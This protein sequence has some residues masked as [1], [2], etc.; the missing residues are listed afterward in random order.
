MDRNARVRAHT[1]THMYINPQ[2]ARGFP[3]PPGTGTPVAPQFRG[4]LCPSPRRS[5]P[6]QDLRLQPANTIASAVS[7]SAGQG[8]LAAP[9]DDARVPLSRD[10]DALEFRKPNMSREQ[11]NTDTHF[12]IFIHYFISLPPSLSIY[13]SL[14]LSITP[15]LSR[16]LPISLGH[17][18]TPS[19]SVS[20][21][22]INAYKHVLLEKQ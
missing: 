14:S 13:Q 15:Y 3:V 6:P 22:S 16:S 9:A 17:S 21:V 2:T 18:L 12:C 10:T 19:L 4:C 20:L 11:T 7:R 8:R 5:S 1:H